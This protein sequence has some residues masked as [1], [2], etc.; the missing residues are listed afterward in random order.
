[1]GEAFYSTPIFRAQDVSSTAVALSG[2]TAAVLA[3]NKINYCWLTA[4]VAILYRWDGSSP[5]TTAYGGHPLPA[6]TPLQLS[7]R[8]KILAF[9][10]VGSGGLASVV[11]FT[12]DQTADSGGLV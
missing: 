1:M 10:F 7:G 9:R 3:A 4:S 12:L 8:K 6:N 2:V 11:T 5:A